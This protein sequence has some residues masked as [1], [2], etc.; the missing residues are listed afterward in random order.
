MQ[1]MSV[2]EVPRNITEEVETAFGVRPD[3]FDSSTLRI[4][5]SEF[6]K[7]SDDYRYDF[8]SLCDFPLEWREECAYLMKYLNQLLLSCGHKDYE[9]ALKKN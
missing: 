8:V 7:P 5:G 9:L 4:G 6:P 2:R 3:H 1:N